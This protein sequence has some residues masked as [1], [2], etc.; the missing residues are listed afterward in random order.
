MKVCNDC[1]ERGVKLIQDF[2]PQSKKERKIQEI[3]QAVERSRANYPNIKK[4][5]KG[6]AN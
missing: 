2:L 1:A 4:K 3:V 6:K 5:S